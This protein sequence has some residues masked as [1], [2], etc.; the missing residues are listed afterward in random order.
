MQDDLLSWPMLISGVQRLEAA[1]RTQPLSDDSLK[2]YYE[3]LCNVPAADFL[4]AVEK[5]I[6]AEDFF[7]SI[8]KLLQYCGV[9]EIYDSSGRRLDNQ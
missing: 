3:K 1:F 2:L 8:S 5:I 7:P 9:E 4:Y 6:E